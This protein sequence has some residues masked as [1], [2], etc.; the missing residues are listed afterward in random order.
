MQ[1]QQIGNCFN[2]VFQQQIRPDLIQPKVD[3]KINHIVIAKHLKRPR[4]FFG[5]HEINF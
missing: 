3:R 4:N 2:D 5:S 1:I